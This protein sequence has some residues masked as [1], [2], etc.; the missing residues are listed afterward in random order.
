M[1]V[2]KVGSKIIV[3]NNGRGAKHIKKIENIFR[4]RKLDFS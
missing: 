3:T 4:L 1:V 2:G